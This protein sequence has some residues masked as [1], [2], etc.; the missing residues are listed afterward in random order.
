LTYA[1]GEVLTYTHLY[2]DIQYYHC[3]HQ[4]P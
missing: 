1:P 4:L 2:G 3:L